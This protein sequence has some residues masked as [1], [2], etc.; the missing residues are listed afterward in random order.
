MNKHK[1]IGKLMSLA[2]RHN[3]GVLKLELDD[4]G[5]ANVD[6]LIAG[7][8]R[9]GIK[10]DVDFLTEIVETNDKQR[11]AFNADKTK[12]RANQGHSI[13]VDLELTEEEPPHTLYHGTVHKFMEAIRDKGLLK[14]SRQ[15]VHLSHTKE[16]AITV[17]S[18]RGKPVIL[19]VEANKMH[20]NGYKFYRS[21]N[22][23]WLTDHVPAE[24]I[25]EH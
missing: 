14:M 9:K 12:I 20:T 15:H 24:Y 16:T 1:N 22:G 19:K 7:L 4:L 8:N 5:W 13:K 25:M 6:Q 2:L 17:G 3:P 10:M 18:R 23:V 11:Y 21:K